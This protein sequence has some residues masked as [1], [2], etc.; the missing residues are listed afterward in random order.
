MVTGTEV[1]S[2]LT[3]FVVVSLAI[4]MSSSVW[5]T[6]TPTQML[7]ELCDRDLETYHKVADFRMYLS[8]ALNKG[9]LKEV[10]AE[11]KKNRI[12]E[13][14]NWPHAP[15]EV[16]SPTT[17]GYVRIRCEKDFV[18]IWYHGSESLVNPG[19][20]PLDVVRQATKG[21]LA[22]TFVLGET[23]TLVG[24]GS[25]PNP[26][27]EIR[28]AAWPREMP[29]KKRI[30]CSYSNVSHEKRPWGLIVRVDVLVRERDLI[31]I[32]EKL[33]VRQA[34]FKY[35]YE[36]LIAAKARL[37][38][39]E[40]E[41]AKGKPVLAN[42]AVFGPETDVRD[43]SDPLLNGCMWPGDITGVGAKDLISAT[44]LAPEPKSQEGR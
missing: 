16:T 24:V 18:V 11:D 26:K 30:T 39:G 9:L 27:A 40:A 43:I 15:V 14:A 13:L 8:K 42:N 17:R 37:D 10:S 25:P 33:R 21:V 35:I 5:A 7:V 31:V 2:G 20:T 6:E 41:L 4:C 23:G 38:K 22:D 32:M 44:V 34:G 1:R 19:A 12:T 28:M 29:G 36:G 3:V